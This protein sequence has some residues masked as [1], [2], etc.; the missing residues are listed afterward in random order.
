[1]ETAFKE[2]TPI[3]ATHYTRLE[4]QPVTGT[5]GAWVSKVQ[6]ADAIDDDELFEEIYAAWLKYQVLFFR[7]QELTPDQQL[8]LGERFGEI[9]KLGYVGSLEGHEGVWVQEYPDMYEG[10]VADI[11]WHS[12]A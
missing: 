8:K 4:A 12:E 7:N 3:E 10:P 9:Q 5:F 1:M 6:L 11:N 2:R